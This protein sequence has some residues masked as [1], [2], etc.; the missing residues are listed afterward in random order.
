MW[1]LLFI[2]FQI[3]QANNHYITNN[4][5]A[6]STPCTGGTYATELR[7]SHAAA[8]G[9]GYTA[10][11]TFAYSP[12]AANNSTVST[13]T[14]EQAFCTSISSQG[15]G[16][17]AVAACQSDTR[18]SC[19]Y[20]AVS[21]TVTCPARIVVSRPASTAW[22]IGAYEYAASGSVVATGTVQVGVVSK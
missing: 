9:Q 19:S 18:Y 15:G 16:T 2:L 11:E 8:N 4:G 14:N 20:N 12:T 5:S 21:N 7:Q 10:V 1:I 13:G 17:D 3:L 22:D 6:Y